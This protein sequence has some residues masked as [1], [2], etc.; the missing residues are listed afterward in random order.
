MPIFEFAQRQFPL[1]S[2]SISGYGSLGL[3]DWYGDVEAQIFKESLENKPTLSSAFNDA[4]G[5][6]FVPYLKNLVR[7]HRGTLTRDILIGAA[8]PP[9]ADSLTNPSGGGVRVAIDDT[10]GQASNI[11][12]LT[13]SRSF[14]NSVGN[15]DTNDYYR[16]DL[17]QANTSF[18]L[19]LN[20]LSANANVEL[21]NSSGALIQRS[22]NSGTR[23]ESIS[24]SLS[25]ATYYVR[26]Y[27]G[28]GNTNYNLTLT[29]DNAGNTP[30][31][32]LNIGT[33]SSSRTFSDFVGSTDTS[34]YYRFDLGQGS[35]FNLTLN[36]LSADADV[37]LL[38]SSGNLLQSSTNT[39][40][41]AEFISRSLTAGTYYVRVFPYSGNT[42]YSLA[43][44]TTVTPITSSFNSTYG[45]GLINAAA[46]VASAIGQNSSF[47]NVAN[48]GGNN[49]G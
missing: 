29:A 44:S 14:Q 17:T 22:A 12:P 25:A 48:L 3:T 18:N 5:G 30:T 6:G 24:R 39:G 41:T 43:L 26:V 45:Y 35:I 2:S 28:S 20:G 13:G 11:G 23:S 49:W 40:T 46:A 33:L 31:T 16:F 47:P 42:N 27:Q 34:V 7:S 21:L 1:T 4:L 38:N 9:A 19:T 8:V 32:A 15:S 37:Q 10:L 36:G